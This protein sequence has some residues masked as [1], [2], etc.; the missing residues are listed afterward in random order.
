MPISDYLNYILVASV[1]TGC[2]SIYF[3]FSFV[4][5]LKKVKLISSVRKLISLLLFS[6]ITASL[7]FLLIGIQGYQMLTEEI[8]VAKVS[9]IPKTDQYFV[10]VV[11]LEGKPEQLFQLAGDEVMFEANV[12][13]WQSWSTVLGLKTAYRLDRVRGR[14]Y[15]IEDEKNKPSTLF[16]LVENGDSDIAAWREK[17]QHLSFLL[18]VEHGSASFASA[19]K[20]MTFDLMM[21]TNGL[22]LRPILENE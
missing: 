16:S 21:T 22:L 10:A 9:I 6:F 3:L 5:H 11:E 14:Y 20:K 13:K 17:Y 7:S 19:D 2:F 8:P 12:L 18:D 15:D 1:V 4:G